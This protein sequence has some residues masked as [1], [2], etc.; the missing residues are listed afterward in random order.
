MTGF[1][2]ANFDRLHQFNELLFTFKRRGKKTQISPK[3]ILFLLLNYVR[4]YPRIEE[5]AAA[6]DLRTPTL[7]K[8]LNKAIAVAAP[9]WTTLFITQPALNDPLPSDPTFPEAS[10]IVDATV[11]Q[12]KRPIGSFDDQKQ[13][14]SGKHGIYCLKAQVITNMNGVA[15]HICSGVRGATHDLE[16]FRKTQCELDTIIEH[17]EELPDKVLGDKGYQAQDIEC[18]ITPHKGRI[19]NLTRTEKAFNDRHAKSRIVI[20]N[21]FG[22]LKS[23]YAIISTKYRSDHDHYHDAFSLCCALVNFE[24]RNCS[25]PL[26]KEDADFYARMNVQIRNEEDERRQQQLTARRNQCARRMQIHTGH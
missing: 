6:F 20:E 2:I 17:H 1:T 15:V 19:E 12:I 3:D 4:R 14:Y 7:G 25:S 8:I 24:I 9:F 10:F 16:I 23:R 11:Q 5:M 18:L 26:R 22:R 13:W 21:F